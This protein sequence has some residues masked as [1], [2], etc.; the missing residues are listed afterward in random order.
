[1]YELR[2][3]FVEGEVVF[4]DAAEAI[5]SHAGEIAPGN[6]ALI[7]ANA[8]RAHSAY[9]SFRLGK[10]PS[11][12]IAL[13]SSS[14]SLHAS[15]DQFAEMCALWY[16]GLVC[17]VLGKYEE[18]NRSLQASLE[19]AKVHGE[20]WYETMIGEHIG[21]VLHDHGEYEMARH[22]L[23]EAVASARETGDPMVIAHTLIFFGK[24]IHAM[25]ETTEAE[26]CLRESLNIAQE[27]GYRHGIGRA[28]DRLGQLAEVN[29]PNEARTLFAASC[30][31]HRELGDLRTLSMVFN[32]QGYNSLTFG[33]IIGAHN[34]FITVLRLAR[35]GSYMPTTLDALVGLAMITVEDGDDEHALE[36]VVH[37]LQHQVAAHDTL[38]RAERLQAELQTRLTK[39]QLEALQTR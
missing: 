28:L 20:Q 26:K 8:M 38:T 16:L 5:Q 31:V 25:G 14:A 27:I 18:A 3:W 29:N 17:W 23:A 36:L 30:D 35:E 13:I 34:S 12:Y 24:T 22:Y 33:D 21:I 32:H 4:R 37:V 6:E 9:F 1:V 39:Q 15:T 19:K 10:N 2:N 7:A 11:A